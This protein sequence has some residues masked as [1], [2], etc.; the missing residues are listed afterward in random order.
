MLLSTLQ[1]AA[2]EAKAG[3]VINIDISVKPLADGDL[4]KDHKIASN[5]DIFDFSQMLSCSVSYE[6]D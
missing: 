4:K 5:I 3:S 1:N 2:D 6:H